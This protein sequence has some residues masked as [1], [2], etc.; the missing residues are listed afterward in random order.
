M[1]KCRLSLVI[2]L[3]RRPDNEACVAETELPTDN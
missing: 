3:P 1:A 2:I